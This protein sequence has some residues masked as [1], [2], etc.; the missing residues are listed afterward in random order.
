MCSINCPNC[1]EE[2]EKVVGFPGYVW[3]RDCHVTKEVGEMKTDVDKKNNDGEMKE[4]TNEICD[5]IED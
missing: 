3:C 1:E 2:M 4:V 5:I